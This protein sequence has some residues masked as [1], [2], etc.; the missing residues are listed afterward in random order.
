MKIKNV[1]AF[2]IAAVLFFSVS[3]FAKESQEAQQPLS[4]NPVLNKY[5][6]DKKVQEIICVHFVEDSTAI[7]KMYVRDKTQDSGWNLILAT[8]AFIGQKGLGKEQEG[9]LKTPEGDFN[10]T[11]AFGIKPNPGTSLNYI[12]VN[13][14][15]YACD[16]E[17][18]N[19]LKV[20]YEES[21][22]ELE[23]CVPFKYTVPK[24]QPLEAAD[25][26]AKL[27]T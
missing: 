9:D 25:I 4:R 17:L 11:Q 22:K 27:K 19:A 26:K 1:L 18:R 13:N 21:Q 6:K 16:E 7:L 20:R 24:I 2:S 3:I 10:V 8:D 23:N 5:Q 15:I 14:N 12:N